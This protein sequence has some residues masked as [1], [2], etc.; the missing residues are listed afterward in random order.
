MAI[1]MDL[2]SGQG[3]ASKSGQEN[4]G[5]DVQE[6]VL[7]LFPAVS[8]YRRFCAS[9][10]HFMLF[11]TDPV[12]VNNYVNIIKLPRA[13]SRNE[14]TSRQ[15]DGYIVTR[16]RPGSFKINLLNSCIYCS[17]TDNGPTDNARHHTTGKDLKSICETQSQQ[18]QQPFIMDWTILKI[19]SLVWQGA[20]GV[21][22]PIFGVSGIFPENI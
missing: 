8:C 9:N 20:G 15:T 10:M 6:Y 22:P 7:F 11:Q 14:Y 3:A 4:L 19:L 21:S 12:I 13:R 16:E 1:N 18:Q 17:E 5:F 2:G